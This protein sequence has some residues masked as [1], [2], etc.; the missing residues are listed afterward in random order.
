MKKT[1]NYIK[2][3]IKINIIYIIIKNSSYLKTFYLLIKND[4]YNTHFTY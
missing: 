4:I 1:F 3:L 2:I